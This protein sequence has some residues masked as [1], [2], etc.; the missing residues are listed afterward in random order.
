MPLLPRPPTGPVATSATLFAC[1]FAVQ[2]SLLALT[3]ILTPVAQDLGVPDT[4]AGLLRAVSGAAAAAVAI[5]LVATRRR[6]RLRELLIAG[7]TLLAGSALASAVAPTYLV[8][9][10][11]QVALGAGVA[12]VLAGGMAA[13]ARWAPPGRRAQVLSWALVGQ[14]SAWIAG[15]P[16]IGILGQ[17]NW[18]LAWLVPM[19]ASLLALAGT[20]RRETG[21]PEPEPH[22]ARALVRRPG[23]ARWALGELLAYGGWAGVLVYCGS[24]LTGAHGV[25]VAAAGLALGGGAAGFVVGTMLARRWVDRAARPLLLAVGPALAVMTLVFGALRPSFAFSVAAF[26]LVALLSG[27]R[28]IAGSAVGLDLDGVGPLQSMSL[29]ATSVQLGYLA[30]SVLG[31]A[32][33][34]VAGWTGLGVVLAALT[35]ASTATVARRPVSRLVKAGA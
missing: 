28:V 23:A 3:P 11:A 1:L 33:L 24:L 35:L 2:A 5:A 17:Q 7:L 21:A 15:M 14:P 31:G 8:L 29:R 32:G 20:I 34:A 10:A 12:I 25:S 19:T 4:A 6:R 16:V 26:A 27:A 30:G 22:P 9:A 13:A 18:R